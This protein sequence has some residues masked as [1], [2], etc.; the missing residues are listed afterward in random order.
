MELYP[1]SLSELYIEWTLRGEHFTVFRST[2]PTDHFEVVAERVNQPFYVDNYVNL[3]DENIRY[4]YRVDGFIGDSKVS[5]DGPSTLEYNKKD[6]VANKVIHE[7]KVVL[8]V[9]NNPPVYF[10]LR[11]REGSPC[12][13]CWNPVTKKIRFSNCRDCNGTGTLQG[14]HPPIVSRI[15]QD[16]SQ[17]LSASGERDNDKVKLTPIRAWIANTPLLYPD[18]IMVDVLNQRYKIASVARR[19]RSQYVIR[20]VLDLVPIEKGH[21]AY[22]VEVDRRVKPQ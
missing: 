20:Q 6:G 18:D 12:P 4:Y 9:M 1:T 14:Y 21:P 2:S 8:R 3:Y 17:L 19:T 13:E 7:T 5:E 16:V 15:S 22:G 11:N 10:L